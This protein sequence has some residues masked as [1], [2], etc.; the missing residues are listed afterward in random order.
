MK[1]VL[2][3]VL[4]VLLLAG[5]SSTAIADEAYIIT[6]YDVHIVVS[7]NNVLDVVER[8]TVDYSLERHGIYYLRQYRGTK[9][10]VIDGEAVDTDFWYKISNFKVLGYKFNKSTFESYGDHYLNVRIGD[11]DVYVFGEQEYIITYKSAL[12]DD[13]FSEFDEFYQDLIFCDYED[14]VQNASF[15][16]ELPKDIDADKVVAYLGAYGSQS[17]TG[18]HIEVEDN[19]IRG[20]TLRAMRGGEVLTVRAEM[21]DGY[22]ANVYDPMLFWKILVFGIAGLSVLI[23]F[24]LWLA[25][26]NDEKRYPTV[27]FYAPDDMTSAEAGYIIDGTVDDADIISLLIYWASK[28][29]IKIIEKSK[30][31]I[32]LQKLKEL[33]DTAKRFE[34]NLFS[35][36]FA[37]GD[38]VNIATLKNTFYT[39]MQTA[40]AGVKNYFESAKKRRVF[41]KKSRKARSFMGLLTV[42]P[43]AMSMYMFMYTS[44]SDFIWSVIVAVAVS[45]LIAIPVFMLVRLF[46]RWRSTK[47]SKRVAKLIFSLILLG[48]VLSVYTFAVPFLEIFSSISIELGFLVTLTTTVATLFLMWM[49]SIMK[50]R[51]K[52]GG[53]WYGKLLGFKNFIEKAE[54][55]RILMLVEENPTYFYDVLPYA[56]V[57]GVTDKWSKK[58]EGIAVAQPDWYSGYR[59]SMFTPM[60]FTSSMTRSMSSIQTAATSR[61]SSSGGGGGFSGGGGGGG[62]S[63]G[64]GGGGGGGGSW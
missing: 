12:N 9:T 2:F 23:A 31:D 59:G 37:S 16:I 15:I 50:K 8:M 34:R 20:Y 7:E 64:G 39:K 22:F 29:H 42:A 13:G 47:K 60:L 63:G 24:L 25:F 10:N 38:L 56:Y 45:V 17:S 4:L 53:E 43:I 44:T 11:P 33:D 58:F 3:L 62:F 18:V 36:L 19:I 41:T 40:K 14:T 35:A 27:E 5:L 55:D 57:L 32:D 30:N 51:T 49:A 54:K 6:D 26:G 21:E 52:Q 61:P 1:K 46:E 28:G 48:I